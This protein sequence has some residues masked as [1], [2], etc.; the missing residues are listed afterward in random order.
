MHDL[1][2]IEIVDLSIT[3]AHGRWTI[4]AAGAI[5]TAIVVEVGAGTLRGRAVARLPRRVV[6]TRGFACFTEIVLRVGSSLVP[7]WRRVHA[8]GTLR[9]GAGE[10]HCARSERRIDAV[11]GTFEGRDLGTL[12]SVGACGFGFSDP[13]RT[14]AVG[15]MTALR[16]R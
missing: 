3:R 14:P 7:S 1:D 6:E 5:N 11:A 15:D 10:F 4:D 8:A 12:T 2:R 13:P 9:A 16:T